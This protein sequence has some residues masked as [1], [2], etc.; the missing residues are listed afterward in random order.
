MKKLN[1]AV[2]FGGVS[3]EHDVSLSSAN[4]I[5]NNMDRNKYTVI[6]IY[7]TKEGKWLLYDGDIQN[8]KA[9]NWEVQGTQAFISP[10]ATLKHIVRIVNDTVKYITVDVI[11][12][13]LHGSN[14]EDGTVQGLF[15]LSQIP[16]VGCNLTSSAISM[17]KSITKK[18]LESININQSA[19]ILY[20]KHDEITEEIYNKINI[21]IGYPCFVKPC[22]A[23]SSFGVS[24]VDNKEDLQL[25]IQN[26]LVFDEKVIIEKAIFGRELECAVL[27]DGS[28]NTIA[29]CIGEV[30]AGNDFYDYDAKYNNDESKTV[31]N[32][33]LEISIVQE[34]QNLAL[35][36][37]KELGCCGL[38]RV[39]FFLENNTNKVIFNEINTLPG[40]TDI[41]MYPMLMEA[42]G[43]PIDE[44]IDKLIDIAMN[45]G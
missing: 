6:P 9:I 20:N 35:T 29:S 30:I 10:D 5:V 39:D 19:Y 12:P 1:V 22:N 13:V 45:C 25:A 33:E 14:G 28:K 24:K 21:N 37:F 16:Y 36:I 2:I 15:E 17:D 43:V 3:S 40:F 44:V 4:T 26:A 34:I 32:P 38:S 11:F 27:G 23:G 18:I 7:I 8:L 42:S 41:S 31:I